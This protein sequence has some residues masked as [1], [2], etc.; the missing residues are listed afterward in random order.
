MNQLA[1]LL[2]LLRPHQWVKSGFVFVGLLFGHVWNNGPVVHQVLLAAVAFSLAASAIYV[3]NDMVDRERDREHPEKRRRPLA[4]GQ[5]SPTQALLLAGACLI[6]ALVFAAAASLAVLAIVS[7]YVLLNVAYSLR[8]KYI[9]LLDVFIVAT[10]FMLRILAGTLGVGIAPSHW[11]ML[12][13]LMLTLF[14]GFAK[15]RAELNALS[16]HGGSHRK[17]LDDYD[18]TLLDELTGICAGGAIISYSLYTVSADTVAMHGTGNLIFTVPFVIYGVFRYLYL[19]HRRGGGGD[20]SA[21][22]LQDYHLLVAFCGWLA[23]VLLLLR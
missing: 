20:P 9:V 12:C 19:L 3:F 22:L 7:A 17:V 10:G 13:G 4:S 23:S 15:R 18:R 21:A 1:L 8:L 11:M 2:K 6:V 14:L 5:V 16:G